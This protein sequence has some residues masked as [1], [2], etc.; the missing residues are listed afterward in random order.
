MSSAL[1]KSIES[2]FWI[3]TDIR[4]KVVHEKAVDGANVAT[5]KYEIKWSNLAFQSTR[6]VHFVKE[7]K[8]L[9][10]VLSLK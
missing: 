10:G 6:C 3:G 7:S 5:T 2:L 1:Y 8:I 9:E 4:Y